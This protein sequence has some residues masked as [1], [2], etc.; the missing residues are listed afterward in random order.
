MTWKQ[1]K[2]AAEFKRAGDQRRALMKAA[3]TKIDAA[4][5]KAWNVVKE[6]MKVNGAL[7]M[8]VEQ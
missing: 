6:D 5:R 3:F 2:D 1:R 8:R 7:N 4:A